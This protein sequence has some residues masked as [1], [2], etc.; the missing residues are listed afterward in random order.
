MENFVM[1]QNI[2][3]AETPRKPKRSAKDKH[4]NPR[5]PL[6]TNIEERRKL[7][8]KMKMRGMTL[9]DM[10]RLLGVQETVVQFDLRKM[11]HEMTSKLSK[12]QKDYAL[13][14]SVSVFEEIERAAWEQYNIAKDA[15]P[16]KAKFLETVKEARKEQIKLLSDIGLIQKQ[17]QKVDVKVDT[18][19]ISH[20]SPAVQDLIAA[21]LIRATLDSQ[22]ERR[23]IDV[24][25]QEQEDEF[26]RKIALGA[27]ELP[28]SPEIKS[29]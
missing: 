11:K 24:G 7:V 21:S 10:A 15:T 1:E 25:N 4:T 16:M 17:T 22:P 13:G 6:T 2:S 18:S 9:K 20:W 19:I 27:Q 26:V 12:I 5:I 8:L 23:M 29:K 28:V 3:V 14:E